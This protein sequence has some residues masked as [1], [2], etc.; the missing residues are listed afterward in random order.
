MAKTT[1]TAEMAETAKTETSNLVLNF[2]IETTRALL[3][4]LLLLSM[5]LN[6]PE[7]VHKRPDSST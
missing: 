2:S 5:M 3:L 4:L 1:E 6:E 7:V